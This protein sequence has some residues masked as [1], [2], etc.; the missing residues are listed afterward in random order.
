MKP[1]SAAPDLV[2]LPDPAKSPE[3][4]KSSDAGSTAEGI[5]A[6]DD[7]GPQKSMLTSDS[8]TPSPSD[9]SPVQIADAQEQRHALRLRLLAAQLDLMHVDEARP[10]F[11]ALVDR[12]E[13]RRR[14]ELI[15]LVGEPLASSTAED[16]VSVAAVRANEIT[17]VLND[18]QHR[19]RNLEGKI[20]NARGNRRQ[21]Q[22]NAIAY[23]R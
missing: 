10:L 17:H 15:L 3:A 9:A 13:D 6:Q 12:L 7:A 21:R 18:A 5:S 8:S 4:V 19:N 20:Y 11:G 16:R 2:I 23:A 1:A 14:R 22:I